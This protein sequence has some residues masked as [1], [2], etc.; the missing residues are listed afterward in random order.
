MVQT[1]GKNL[2]GLKSTKFFIAVVAV[3][4]LGSALCSRNNPLDPKAGNY[5]AGVNLLVDPGFENGAGSW[6]GHTSGGRSIDSTATDAQ[7]GMCCEKI[8]MNVLGYPRDVLQTVRVVAGTVYTFTG[9]MKTDSIGY[10]NA[11]VAGFDAH[12]MVYWYNTATPPQNPLP[13]D[14]VTGF[15][16]ADTLISLSWT[17]P[18]T[19]A[20]KNYRAPDSALS[21]IIYLE[22]AALIGG[23]GHAWFDDLTFNA[24]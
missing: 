5:D 10:L 16:R 18:W 21:A 14:T 13:S 9:C 17:N 20:T 12:I 24:H 19:M 23:T 4:L 7:S 6:Q 15:L 2:Q 22:D 1:D 3:V 11:S 8:D